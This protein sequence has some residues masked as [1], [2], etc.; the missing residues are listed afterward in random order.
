MYD[1]R[2]IVAP[3][4]QSTLIMQEH[5]AFNYVLHVDVSD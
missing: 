2:L 5:I 3:I 1:A 4:T